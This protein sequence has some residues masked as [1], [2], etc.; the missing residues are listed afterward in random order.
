V[1]RRLAAAVLIFTGSAILLAAAGGLVLSRSVA[2]IEVAHPDPHR[3]HAANAAKLA[4]DLSRI[5]GYAAATRT[6]PRPPEAR[7]GRWIEIPVL[8]VALPIREG[9]GS[10]HVP[11]WVALH[12][13]ETPRPGAPG[14]SYLYGHGLW[15]MFGGLLYARVGDEVDLHDYSTG[16]LQVLH[17]SRVVG[18]IRWDDISWIHRRASRPTLVLQTCVD[19]DVHG[20]RFVVQAA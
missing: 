12:Y 14:S 8:H 1:R 9:D 3:G 17:V 2:P 5:S 19:D 18:R 13:P 15:G 10:D 11:Q 4:S 20:A 6:D 16:A 7:T